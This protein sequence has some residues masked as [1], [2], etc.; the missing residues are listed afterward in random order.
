M[1]PSPP[2]RRTSPEFRFS[3]L[4]PGTPRPWFQHDGASFRKP[5]IGSNT[6]IS[7]WIV[8][9]SAKNWAIYVTRLVRTSVLHG[10]SL[11][12]WV[13]LPELGRPVW[14]GRVRLV[15][16]SRD[17]IDDRNTIFT[18]PRQSFVMH[19][20]DGR[21]QSIT[22]SANTPNVCGEFRWNRPWDLK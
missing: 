5:A 11:V 4:H 1:P 7:A 17:V 22:F 21:W 10:K 20:N 2:P 3:L 19:P 8:S 16:W 9:A 18:V 13:V 12:F 14:L 6:A 15:V